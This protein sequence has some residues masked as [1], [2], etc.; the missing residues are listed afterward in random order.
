MCGLASGSLDIANSVVCR[1][2]VLVEVGCVR[3][4]TSTARPAWVW[5]LLHQFAKG[6]T[7]RH[8]PCLWRHVGFLNTPG[9]SP[10]KWKATEGLVPFERADRV[11]D[12][13]GRSG[14]RGQFWYWRQT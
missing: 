3:R 10:S 6:A 4:S 9:R 14:V 1:R 7:G 8:F 11:R 13:V 5:S 12:L 2:P